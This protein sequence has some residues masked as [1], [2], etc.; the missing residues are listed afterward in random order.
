[1]F[2]L[3]NAGSS[4]K[5]RSINNLVTLQRRRFAHVKNNFADNNFVKNYKSTSAEIKLNASSYFFFNLGW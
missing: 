5:L 1:M 4:N 3:I 2:Y